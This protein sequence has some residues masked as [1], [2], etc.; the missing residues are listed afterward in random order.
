LLANGNVLIVGGFSYSSNW[1]SSVEIYEPASEIW[2]STSGLAT[3]RRSHT[4]TLLADGQALVAGG[5]GSSGY[6]ASTELYEPNLG[7]WKTNSALNFARQNHTATL[8]TDGRVLVAG[9]AGGT[10]VMASVELFDPATGFWTTNGAMN[11]P[12]ENHTATLL[13]N[14]QVLVVGGENLSGYLGSAEVY[15]VAAPLPT[16]IVLASAARLPNGAF[17]FAFTNTPGV[18]FTT[19]ATTN[20]S[21]PPSQWTAL[22]GVTEIASGQFQFTDPQATNSPQ[23]FYRVRSP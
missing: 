15:G 20:A 4:A 5:L 9:G 17:Q 11:I 3:G 23:L 18:T 19:L 13:A 8:L 16:L 22:G 2:A 7:T 14:G 1:L 12:R 6:L 10:N 21:L